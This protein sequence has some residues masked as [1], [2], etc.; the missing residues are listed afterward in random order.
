MQ[1]REGLSDCQAAEA[2]QA[3][4]DWKYLLGLG[5]DDPGFDHTVLCEFRGRLL[6]HAATERLVER[7]LDAAREN[8]M[9]RARGR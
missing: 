9:L 1:F 5:L 3:R 2:V 6:E 7:V 4:I 8:G